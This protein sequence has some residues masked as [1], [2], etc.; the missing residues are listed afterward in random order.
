ML[1]LRDTPTGNGGYVYVTSTGKLG[2]RSDAQLAGTTSTV[3][4]GPGWH[5]LELHLSVNGA[6]SLVEVW[7]DGVGIPDLTFATDLGTVTGIALL[8]IGD[9]ATGKTWD[10]ALDDA[11]F[12]SSR[13]GPGGDTNPPSVPANLAATATSAFS[14]QLSWDASSDDVGVTVYDVFRDGVLL[15]QVSSPAYTD[16][17]VLASTSHQYAVRARDVSGN[18]SALSAPASATTPAAA[19]PLF[20]DGF[21]TGDLSAW[22]TASKLAIESNDTNSG[23]FA[24]EG[25]T[26]T[27]VTY[28]KRTLGSTY[29]DAYARV[30]FQ[31]DSQGSQ[32]TLLR[33]RDTTPA[34]NGGYL[35][36][37]SSGKLGF[38]SDALAAGTTSSVVPGP[39]WHVLE[40]H[41]FVNSTSSVV[42]VWLDGVA[43]PDLT[44]S[45][46]DLGTAPIGIVQV[47]DTATTGSWDVVLDDAAFGTSRLGPAG[48]STAPSVPANLVATALLGPGQL[49]C[50]HRRRRGDRLRRDPRWRGPRPGH[51]AWLPGQR[52]ICESDPRVH[53]AGARRV[54]QRFRSERRGLRHDTGRADAGFRRRLRNGQSLCLE[55][56]RDRSGR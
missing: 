26:A 21:E 55:Y 37:T 27:G 38:R 2:Y 32:L 44:F 40:L 30:A 31:V 10:V 20:A 11:A 4:P 23:T 13:L 24:V 16:A 28:A 6:T 7:L 45:T 12:G 3:A 1:R 46:I 43:V 14:V 49:G 54:G 51:L 9:T 15:G 41:L 5:V 19:L 35:Y 29:P 56:G 8:Q 25:T 48:D 17:T 42:E 18:I 39:G 33:L 50:F 47:G 52:R 22:T 36:V 53:D 34:G